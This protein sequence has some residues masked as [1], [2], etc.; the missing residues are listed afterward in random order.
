MSRDNDVVGIL[1][2][3]AA[4]VCF[5]LA[6]LGLFTLGD[7]I[8]KYNQDPRSDI[9]IRF[10]KCVAECES[11]NCKVLSIKANNSQDCHCTPK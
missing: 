8:F 11:I 3:A 2:A 9:Q 10:E 7:K 4:V 6:M 1:L 5:G